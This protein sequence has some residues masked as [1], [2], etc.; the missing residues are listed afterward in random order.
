VS[1]AP[2]NFLIMAGCCLLI[3]SLGQAPAMAQG[4][5]SDA[6]AAGYLS[7]FKQRALDAAL[8]SGARVKGVAYI[9]DQGRLHERTLFSAEADVRGIQVE[10]YLEA[11]GGE[12]T[13]DAIQVSEEARCQLWTGKGSDSGLI[14]VRVDSSAQREVSERALNQTQETWLTA[15][16]EQSLRAQGFRVL[17][18]V[19]AKPQS[20]QDTTY[21]RALVGD[22]SDGPAPDFSVTLSVRRL[23]DDRQKSDWYY[24]H[25]GLASIRYARSS[26][27]KPVDFAVTLA[28]AQPAAQR[29]MGSFRAL[30]E[31]DAYRA[32][33]SG[34]WILD[35][36]EDDLADWVADVT[37][38][39]TSGT[40]C[41]PRVFT[42]TRDGP[43]QYSIDAGVAR[44]VREGAWLL[45]GDRELMVNNVVSDLTLDTLLML[46]VTRADD[47]RA[48]AE[49]LPA[50]E[51]ALVSQAELLGTLP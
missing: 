38:E 26:T 43:Q 45:V 15:A 23:A 21:A 4:V 46:K 27:S 32:F 25:P 47:H 22:W 11:M 2:V 20:Y 35:Q 1:K 37:E 39:F 49:P 50:G 19:G 28:F 33:E 8:D 24:N 7:A 16:L 40:N 6:D 44:G 9:D 30:I 36:D 48:Q 12:G 18:A 10:S 41:L 3:S 13:L 5:S 34:E 14:A 29:S 51:G 31:A 42:V 17:A